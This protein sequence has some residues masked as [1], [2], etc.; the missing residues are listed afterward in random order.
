[1]FFLIKIGTFKVTWQY[2]AYV[3]SISSQVFENDK[4]AFGGCFGHFNMSH[5]LN[6]AIYNYLYKFRHKSPFNILFHQYNLGS[7][8]VSKL[9]SNLTQT[10]LSRVG[11]R[12]NKH[13]S[14]WP[15]SASL[16]FVYY[17]QP[18]PRGVNLEWDLSIC[19]VDF[20]VFHSTGNK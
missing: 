16:V 10:P 15:L 20:C 12:F 11:V 6:E 9:H 3:I 14:E 2:L 18:F 4:W 5:H 7:Y 13:L 19:Q 8:T 17:T 1:M